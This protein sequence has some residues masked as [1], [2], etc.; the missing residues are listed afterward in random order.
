MEKAAQAEGIV[1]AKA[2]CLSEWD[3]LLSEGTGWR[4]ARL[5]KEP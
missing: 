1:H 5:P 2:Q 4:G 3:V